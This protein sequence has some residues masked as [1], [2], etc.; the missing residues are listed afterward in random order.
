M[1]VLR[2][3]ALLGAAVLTLVATEAASKWQYKPFNSWTDEELKEIV[4]NSPWAGRAD[5]TWIQTPGSSFAPIGQFALVSWSSALP[6]RQ[7][8]ERSKLR[9]GTAVPRETEARLAATQDRYIIT[10]TIRGTLRPSDTLSSSERIRSVTT[11]RPTGK[12]P[13]LPSTIAERAF[14]R[15]GKPIEALTPD[16]PRRAAMFLF[17]FPKTDP[18]TL[19]NKEVEFRTTLCSATA[20]KPDWETVSWAAFGGGPLGPQCNLNVRKK[21]KLRDMVYNGELAL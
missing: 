14:D 7:A 18:L 13:L 3:F 16:G 21:F 2:F 11:L 10:V 8:E 1:N 4:T 9:A 17:M 20:P 6:L 12:P 5:L 19:G 15:D